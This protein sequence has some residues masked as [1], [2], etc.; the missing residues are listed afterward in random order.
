MTS[1]WIEAA[2][3]RIVERL[4]YKE[5]SWSMDFASIIAAI[6]REEYAKHA[7]GW[8]PIESAPKDGSSVLL[9]V[10]SYQCVGSWL[11]TIEGGEWCSGEWD[12]EPTHWMPLPSPPPQE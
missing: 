11:N 7:P 3:K 10:P 12:V 2:A 6:I 4:G 8:R 1:D 9:F 5:E